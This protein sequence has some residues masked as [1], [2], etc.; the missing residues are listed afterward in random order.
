MKYSN[1]QSDVYRN[2]LLSYESV[3]MLSI[4]YTKI[5]EMID[6]AVNQAEVRNLNLAFYLYSTLRD[7]SVYRLGLERYISPLYAKKREE[8]GELFDAPQNIR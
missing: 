5:I 7:S 6:Y 3:E 1:F 8:L 4:I 2:Y